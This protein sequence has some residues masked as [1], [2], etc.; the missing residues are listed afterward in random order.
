MG[1]SNELDCFDFFFHFDRTFD[2]VSMIVWWISCEMRGS[3]SIHFNFSSIIVAMLYVN[4]WCYLLVEGANY[5]NSCKVKITRC[6]SLSSCFCLLIFS[7]FSVSRFRRLLRLW[8]L[9]LAQIWRPR[10]HCLPLII[11]IC[12]N[13]INAQLC[14]SGDDQGLSCE[15]LHLM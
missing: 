14:N 3:C 7:I 12:V 9:L 1:F 11:V 5:N 15:L 13:F 2:W 8:L 4:M 6:Q 10:K